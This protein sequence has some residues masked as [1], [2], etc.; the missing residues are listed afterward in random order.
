MSNQRATL[1]L[2]IV[3]LTVCIFGYGPWI[4]SGFMNDD[5]IT[6]NHFIVSLLILTIF[7]GAFIIKMPIAVAMT[8][9]TVALVLACSD[10]ALEH[11]W[12]GFV[13]NPIKVIR[14]EML[15]Y[16]KIVPSDNTSRTL[17]P[18]YIIVSGLACM[19]VLLKRSRK[20]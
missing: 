17:M 15:D 5:W 7:V 18:T 9:F 19:L 1:V 3:L 2:S 16:Y 14:G 6:P 12:S 11:F 4:V 8:V 20:A 10:I 13:P